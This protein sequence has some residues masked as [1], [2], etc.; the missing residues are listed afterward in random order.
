[1]ACYKLIFPNESLL[2][3]CDNLFIKSFDNKY[4]IKQKATSSAFNLYSSVIFSKSKQLL[5]F[6]PPKNAKLIDMIDY[7]YPINAEELIDGTMINLYWDPFIDDWDITTKDSIGGYDIGLCNKNFRTMFLESLSSQFDISKIP[8][9]SLNGL[10]FVFCFIIQHKENRIVSRIK[11]H[12]VYLIHIYEIDNTSSSSHSIVNTIHLN[13]RYS[14]ESNK[15]WVQLMQELNI[16][17]PKTIIQNKSCDKSTINNLIDVY[18]SNITPYNIKGILI[19][20]N[21]S[22]FLIKHP[23][24]ELLKQLRC[25]YENKLHQYLSLKKEKKINI[26]LNYFYEDNKLFRRYKK[27]YETFIY[28][29]HNHYIKCYILHKCPLKD[30]PDQFKHLL[31]ELHEVYKHTKTK[32]TLKFVKQYFNLLHT[33][34][35]IYYLDYTKK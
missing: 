12:S 13:D 34:K 27:L 32:I 11:E 15:T 28:K 3:N 1:M 31:F 8:E 35:Q 7:K 21:A 23:L 19:K 18:S 20:Q 26:Y 10:P 9:T 22:I 16:K 30:I 5:S 2:T 14:H 29:L 4:L 25:N 6:F 33:K 17:L 24:Y